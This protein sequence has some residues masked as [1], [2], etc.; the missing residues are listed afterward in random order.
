MRYLTLIQPVTDP[1][2]ET[3]SSDA[4]YH[5]TSQLIYDKIRELTIQYDNQPSLREHYYKITKYLHPFGNIGAHIRTPLRPDCPPLKITNAFMKM[6]EF[7]M[8]LKRYI[9]EEGSWRM[10]DVAGAPGMFIIATIYYLKRNG[11][12]NVDLD[13][14]TCSFLG[15]ET[16]LQDYYRIYE[17]NPTRFINCDLTKPEDLR[18][19]IA[20]GKYD[21]VTGDL[22]IYHDS[23][24]S[25][26]QEETHLDAQYGQAILALNLSQHKANVFLKMYTY[27]T[28]ES[29]YLVDLLSGFFEQTYICKPFTSRLMNDESYIIC[30]NRND[31]DCSKIPLSRKYFTSYNSPNTRLY[32][33]FDTIR[34]DYKLQMVSLLHRILQKYPNTVFKFLLQN[35]SYNIYYQQ[36]RR[37][38]DLFYSIKDEH[39]SDKNE[40]SKQ[41]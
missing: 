1:K 41:D 31:R 6:Y 30:L 18:T 7:L 16:S 15:S 26:L 39:G 22:G 9:P 27:A 29:R 13:W 19:C 34:S 36:F 37:L 12:K 21:L 24:F 40:S 11:F 23:D 3:S 4:S 33:S 28:E 5:I 2:P 20:T 10:F 35:H 14:Y 38:F 32:D 25:K 17:F 8:F